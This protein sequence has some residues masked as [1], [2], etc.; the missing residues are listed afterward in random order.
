[1]DYIGTS[2][3]YIMA[4]ADPK[5]LISV[6]N[7]DQIIKTRYLC[8][9][10]NPDWG[11]DE[12]HVPIVSNDIEGISRNAHLLLSVWDYDLTNEDDVIGLDA[13]TLQQDL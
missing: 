6:R 8:R 10:L 11:K 9:T 12:L 3:P 1:M 7:E 13:Y 5:N 2:D 4:T